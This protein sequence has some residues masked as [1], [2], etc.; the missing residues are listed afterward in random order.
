[1]GDVQAAAARRR[2]GE[3]QMVVGRIGVHADPTPDQP[4]ALGPRAAVHDPLVH[5]VCG[6]VVGSAVVDVGIRLRR[7]GAVQGAGFAVVL[8][9]LL[10]VVA[11]GDDQAAGVGP[12][13]GDGV[14]IHPGGR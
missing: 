7:G 5:Q 12:G 4:G 13:V 6:Q 9:A 2:L 11:A 10:V 3:D 1:A 14:Q 8:I